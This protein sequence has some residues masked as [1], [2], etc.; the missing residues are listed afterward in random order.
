MHQVA[1]TG[2]GSRS[3]FLIALCAVVVLATSLPGTAATNVAPKITGWPTGTASTAT[4]GVKYWVQA[5]ATDANGDA[6]TFSIV[7]KPVWAYFGAKSGALYGTPTSA[8]VKTYSGIVIS[9]SDGKV[10]VSLPAFSIRVVSGSSSTG[11][12]A[13]K[14]SGSPPTSATAGISYSFKPTA[15]DANGDKLTFSIT[16]KP[17]WA[18]FNTGTGQLAGIP[19]SSYV[20]TTSGIAIKVSDGKLTAALPTFSI[21]VKSSTTTSGSAT[22]S[23]MPP[24]TNTNGSVLTNLAGYR[25]SYGTSSTSL[26]RTVQVTNAGLTRYVIS[27]LTPGTW[28]F[29][30]QAYTSGGVTSAI[31]KLGI[32][33]IK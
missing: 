2:F 19:S 20:G 10:K 16:N 5:K 31:S 14:I 18:T 21:A 9:V 15:S 26:T 30:L 32:K 13:P 17:G 29:G 33:T 6:L 23:W 11:N 27:N 7:N 4:V 8:Q 12:A 28:Y 22:V 3:K 24:T 1:E 25:I